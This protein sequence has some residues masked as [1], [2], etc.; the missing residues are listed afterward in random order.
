MTDLNFI[1]EDGGYSAYLKV[2]G[3]VTLHIEHAEGVISP[4]FLSLRASN[5]GSYAPAYSSN[6]IISGSF[7]IGDGNT[8]FNVR[9]TTAK[10][11]SIGQWGGNNVTSSDVAL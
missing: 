5:T 2:T 3:S 8:E 7:Q 6:S 9:I 1:A 10:L 4:V 11:P